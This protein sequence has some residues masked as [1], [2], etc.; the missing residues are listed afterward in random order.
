MI[1]LSALPQVPSTDSV[2]AVE[3][4]CQLCSPPAYESRPLDQMSPGW[5]CP[6]FRGHFGLP[7]VL[8]SL[9]LGDQA[10]VWV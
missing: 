4:M 5:S 8:W 10:T 6:R 1:R 2:L 3:P 7:L 9:N